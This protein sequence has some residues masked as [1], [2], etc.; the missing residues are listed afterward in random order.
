VRLAAS[1]AQGLSFGAGVGVVPVSDL[2]AVAQRVLQ[3]QPGVRRVVVVNDAR[4]REVYWGEFAVEGA[5]VEAAGA[6]QVSPAT[7]VSLPGRGEQPWGAAGR[8]LLVSP[9]LAERCRD[10]GAVLHPD[11][12]PHAR[13]ILALARQAVSE[14]RILP[15]ERAL[16]VYVRDRVVNIGPS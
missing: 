16:P 7:Q 12:L 13:E 6:E 14:R 1:V 9:E 11:L 5:L 10:A 8:G 2:A 3:L 4:M 15:A